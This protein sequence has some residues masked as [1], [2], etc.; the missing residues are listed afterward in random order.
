LGNVSL[1]RIASCILLF[2]ILILST[3]SIIQPAQS[4]SQQ[5]QA[6]G[7]SSDNCP[8]NSGW[9]RMRAQKWTHP[10]LSGI[11]ERLQSSGISLQLI[12]NS[13]IPVKYDVYSVVVKRMPPGLAPEAFLN[14]MAVDINKAVN[15]RVF[16]DINVFN[17]VTL[18]EPSIGSIYYLDM[19]FTDNGSVILVD[20]TP[21]SFILQTVI[22]NHDGRHPENGA[23]EFGFE[24]VE[25]GSGS[26]IFYTRGVSQA[27]WGFADTFGK[28]LQKI[29]W[30]AAMNGI[31]HEM[32]RR[33]GLWGGSPV[34]GGQVCEQVENKVENKPLQTSCTVERDIDSGFE[35]LNLAGCAVIS[36]HNNDDKPHTMTSGYGPMDPNSAKLFDSSIVNAG[37][38]A[39]VEI[40]GGGP[41]YCSVHPYETGNI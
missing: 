35:S 36:F 22:S 6:G 23:R 8:P 33:G 34:M 9:D 41:Y 37:E 1:R 21:S 40:K 2:A 32:S 29:G 25:D 16:N 18:G 19:K 30:T 24:R 11:L 38:T 39:M 15:N 4:Q 27:D 17:K 10:A 28:A 12:E 7:G 31:A 26:V 20:K 14:E 13:D 3:L 5:Q